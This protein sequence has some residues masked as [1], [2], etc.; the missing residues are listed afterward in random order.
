MNQVFLFLP[1][2]K[3]MLNSR[4][5]E[6]SVLRLSKMA[7]INSIMNFISVTSLHLPDV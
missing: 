7:S 6:I 3:H 5:V 4:E 1:L 2:W